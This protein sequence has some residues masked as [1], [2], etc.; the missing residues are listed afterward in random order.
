MVGKAGWDA[1]NPAYIKLLLS[2]PNILLTWAVR[3]RSGGLGYEAKKGLY[4]EEDHIH[5]AGA[6]VE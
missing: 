4:K 3:H 6:C 1:E 2:K 5:V